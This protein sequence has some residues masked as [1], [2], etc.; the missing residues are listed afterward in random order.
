MGRETGVN[1][2]QNKDAAYVQLPHQVACRRQGQDQRAEHNTNDHQNDDTGARADDRIA[3]FDIWLSVPSGPFSFRVQMPAGAFPLAPREALDKHVEH[4]RRSLVRL[5]LALRQKIRIAKALLTR[6][7][8]A[9]RTLI[10]GGS[11]RR[12]AP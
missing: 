6:S 9:A 2:C 4:S 5:A 10:G 1:G 8:D 3:F 11:A 7:L 12:P